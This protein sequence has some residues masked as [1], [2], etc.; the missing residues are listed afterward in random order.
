MPENKCLR[1]LVVTE[2]FPTFK[3][4]GRGIFIQEQVKA[5]SRLH[6]VTVLFPRPNLP[7]VPPAC[8]EPKAQQWED[9]ALAQQPELPVSIERPGYFYVPR[10]RGIRSWQL[11]RLVR[12]TLR[13]ATEPY[14]IVHAH[15][16]APAGSAAVKAVAGLGIP[17]IVTAHA[18]DVYRD[19]K[20]TKRF[21]VAQQVVKEASRIIAV[22]NYF[23]ES[24]QRAGAAE[25]K[26]RFIPNGVD[27]EVFA[28][29]DSEE[30]RK[31]LQL[32]TGVPLYLYIGN[33]EKA[34][35]V[36]DVV[37]A[38]LS[39]A[40]QEA[41][42][43]VAGTGPLFETIAWQSAQSHGRL[44]LRGWQSHAAVARYLA[45][46]DCFVLVSYA[47]GNPVT[48]LESLCCGKPVIGSGIAAI[49]PLIKDGE[50]GLLVP[51]GDVPALGRA[52]RLLPTVSWDHLT[53]SRQAAVCYG[54]KAVVD[55]ISD[56][57]GE[58]IEEAQ[59]VSGVPHRRSRVSVGVSD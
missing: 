22:G 56:V 25:E 7:F 23:C 31:E 8:L 12:Y 46:A 24:L 29:A 5:L 20:M 40:P 26:L 57:Y 35:G 41:V 14:D 21:Q 52:M 2:S 11:A 47:E 39:C 34:K 19:L 50:N 13:N 9:I 43:V 58:A 18:G 6:A 59:A 3:H 53:I 10:H 49:A 27:L 16:L 30:A 45:A 28:P 54:W 15:W 44:I 17:V 32:P 4:P 33:L 38:F 37:E 1:V 51:P 42:L 36:S 48:V 55:R